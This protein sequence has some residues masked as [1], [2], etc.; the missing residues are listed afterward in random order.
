MSDCQ[1]QRMQ[2]GDIVA[3]NYPLTIQRTAL[4]L[5]HSRDANGYLTI[6]WGTLLEHMWDDGDLSLVSRPTSQD[7]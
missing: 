3:R 7:E 1:M 2:P 4:G 5:V 6:M